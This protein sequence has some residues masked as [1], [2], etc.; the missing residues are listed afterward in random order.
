MAQLQKVSWRT[1]GYAALG[2][3]VAICI[4]VAIVNSDGV[5]PTSLTS[6]AATRWLVDQVNGNVVLVDGLAGR[7]LAKIDTESD[8]SDEVAVQGA[9][10]AFLVTPDAGFGAHHLDRQVAAGNTADRGNAGR[11]RRQVRVGD[12]GLTVVSSVTN[13]ASVVAVDDVSRGRSRSP[14]P[15][16]THC[17]R[18]QHVALH[19]HRG[20]PRQRR[21]IEQERAAAQR[22]HPDNHGRRSWRCVRRQHPDGALARRCRRVLDTIPNATEA[23]LQEPGDDAPCVW[24]GVGDTLVCVGADGIDQQLSID[25][26]NIGSDDRLA[27]AGPTAVVVRDNNEVNR[28]DLETRRWSPPMTDPTVRIGGARTGDHCQRRPDLA[29]RSGR[30]VAWVVHRFGIN[31]INKNDEAP[32]FDA[33]GQVVEQ[34]GPDSNGESSSAGDQAGDDD[35]PPP[36]DDNGHDD[37]PNAIDDSVTARAGNTVTIPVTANDYDP[38]GDPIAV[39]SVGDVDKAG[40]GTTDVLDGTSVAYVPDLGYSGTDSFDYTIVDPQGNTASATVNVELFAADSPNRPPIARPDQVKT[41]VGRPVIIDVLGNDIDPERDM[42]TV[43]TFRENSGATITAATGP[44]GLPALL[45]D[46]PPGRPGIYTFTYQAADPQGGTSAKTVVT[47]EV[48]SSDATNDPPVAKNDAIRL[49]V[50]STKPINVKANDSDPDGDDLTITA[51][52]PAPSGIEA[53]VLGQQLSI[54]LQPGAQPLSVVNYW[55]N[56]G[57][58]HKVV[59]HVLVVR[60]N[61]TAVNRPPVANPDAERVVLGNTVKI[62]VTTNDIDPDNDTIRLLTVDQPADG[63][64]SARVEGNSV[65]FTPN[66][67]EIT[68]PTPVI[69]TYRITDGKGNEVQGT[70]TIT[71]LVEALPAAPYARDDFADTVTDKPVNIDVLANDSDPSGGTPSLRGD[72][73]CL[74]GGT[75]TKT[76][77]QRVAFTPPLGAVGTFRCKYSVRSVGGLGAEASIIVTVASAP[78]GNHAPTVNASQTQQEVKIGASLTL[79]ANSIASDDDGDSLVFASVSK[80]AHGDTTFTQ[81]AASFVYTAPPTGSAD[82]TPD[83]DSLDVTISDGHDGNVRTTISIRIIDDTP[84]ST[85]PLTHDIP[86]AATVDETT[87]FDVVAELRDANPGTTLTLVSAVPASPTPDAAVA[88]SGGTS[89]VITPRAAGNLSITY[90]VE[91]DSKLRASGKLNVAIAEAPPV[92]PPPVA[93]ADELTVASGGVG[94]V[95]LLANDLGIADTGDSPSVTLVNRPPTSFG[96]VEVHNGILTMTAGSGPSGGS[97]TIRYQVGDGSGQTSQANV[98]LTIQPCSDSAPV[99]NSAQVFTP[100]ET[101]IAIDLR[102]LVVSGNFVPGSISGAGLTGPTG[103][104]TPPVGMNSSELVTFAVANGCEEVAH[105]VLTIDVN[106]PPVGGTIARNLSPGDSLTLTVNDL[107]SDDEALSISELGSTAPSW[108]TIVDSTTINISPPNN[109][110]SGDYNFTANVHD[111]GFLTATASIRLSITNLP[112]TALADAYTTEFSQY[113]FDPT[114]NDFDSEPGPL[115]VQI[116]T[117]LGGPAEILGH[118]GNIYTVSLPHGISTFNYTIVDSGG[119]TASSTITITSNRPPTVGDIVDSTNQPT[120]D[121]SLLPTD[122]DGDALDVSCPST[123]IFDVAVIPDPSPSNPA[124][125]TLHVTVIPEHFTDTSSFTCTVTDPFGAKASA[126]VTLTI[127]D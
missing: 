4:V 97:A 13:E 46:P 69:F 64:G 75:A 14:K 89:V 84:T 79:N 37:P 54:T 55:L 74:N 107:A 17:H 104:Y 87:R 45:Y 85:P 76:D 110:A 120:I 101:P 96:T 125:V 105:G 16:I 30:P 48:T 61:D 126:T 90:V 18:R 70:V 108:V 91:N 93:V 7:V 38:D 8:S 25:G 60:I 123:A 80:P 56:D 12:S 53:K 100:Y 2:T 67:P 92:N 98:A 127:T 40:H 113:T 102:P 81:K 111:L 33:Q 36:A 1:V 27:V 42:L 65:R 50:G 43:S 57:N 78:P 68:E 94:S 9:G 22:T 39:V 119:M 6:N 95:D 117:P 112:P 24:V 58:G 72:P 77:D 10:G 5:R 118:V 52:T 20:D 31:T 29:R 62:A 28:I 88:T 19:R 11:G 83:A 124:E 23:V 44:T 122:P 51:F 3:I 41:R 49:P 115:A 26:L 47:V 121:L 59:G 103:T 106:R 32:Q 114:V 66:L 82:N 71:V 34:A 109:T 63:G 21:R 35:E 15:T 73:V 86:L 99:V 116:I